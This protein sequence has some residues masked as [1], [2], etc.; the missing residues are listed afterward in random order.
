MSTSQVQLSERA[1]ERARIA[2]GGVFFLVGL[3]FGT[4]AA[5]IPDFKRDLSLSDAQLAVAFVCLEGAA[6]AG[7]WVGGALAVRIGSGPA[8][9]WSIPLFAMA[10][11]VLGF[12]P[13]LGALGATVAM[14]ALAN[15]VIDVAMNAQGVVVERRLGRPLMSAFHAMHP[16]GG[17]VGSAVGALAAHQS[18]DRALHL[19]MVGAVMLVLSF[20]IGPRL[21]PGKADR[22]DGER[23]GD[24]TGRGWSRPL[25]LFSV[26]A[27]CMTF[28]DGTA[29]NWSAVYLR[30][31]LHASPGVAG[32]VVTAFLAAMA[33]GRLVGNRLVRR[34]GAV[35]VFRVAALIGGLGLAAG[36][37]TDQVAGGFL[38]F[39][40]FGIGA[41]VTL[42]LT[43][44]AAGGLP[45]VDTARAVARV[46]MVGY[47]GSFVAPALVGGL[48]EDA[49]LRVALLLPAALVLATLP[50]AHCLR[51]A[52][53]GPCDVP[54]AR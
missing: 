9:R 26:M 52:D 34:Y 15:S 29:N 39:A 50:L 38:G 24:R 33:L 44:A 40:V 3:A 31:V 46:S 6:V 10:L 51:E 12:V 49:G 11:A 54:G 5:R 41:S 27:F 48:T 21:L 35:R 30:D 20:V 37:V 17:I 16:I 42:P 7:L 2:I 36:T 53:S 14:F 45:D 4:W 22:T 8:V 19:P 18:V 32:A 28:A 13:G 1:M 25:V 47:V 43:L 23:S